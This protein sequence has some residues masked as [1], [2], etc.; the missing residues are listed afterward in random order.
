VS[1]GQSED[2]AAERSQRPPRAQTRDQGFWFVAD[3]ATGRW[4]PL[5]C[6]A[7]QK[8]KAVPSSDG[9]S[10]GCSFVKGELSHGRRAL[11]ELLKS[12]TV[13]LHTCFDG[14]TE[15]LRASAGGIALDAVGL[16]CVAVVG[17]G[18]GI[19]KQDGVGL[20][21][22]PV[23]TWYAEAAVESRCARFAGPAR[24]GARF[25]AVRFGAFLIFAS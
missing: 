25:A 24:R 2:G 9:R 6:L 20:A 4:L 23:P 15:V 14:G 12:A 22:A 13:W 3:A 16:E 10:C 11:L 17:A 8:Q 18:L 7:D 5:P 21:G 1:Y 19:S